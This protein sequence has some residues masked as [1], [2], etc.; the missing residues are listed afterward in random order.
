MTA[1]HMPHTADIKEQFAYILDYLPNGYAEDTRPIHLRKPLAQSLGSDYFILLELSIKEGERVE[2]ESKVFVGKGERDI[3]KHV[4][5]RLKYE[6]LTHTAEIEL[7]VIIEHIVK[8]NEAKYVEF[9]NMAQPIT[10]RLHMLELLPGIGKKMMWA[11]IDER[12]KGKFKSFRE[13]EER[14]K[15]LHHPDKLIAK[16]IEEEI[17]DETIKYRLFAK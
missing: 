17:K 12:K 7:P 6:E 16:R 10:T 2:I 4:E 14:V 15:G 8:E 13:I 11:I 3:V 5:R 1:T 9:Y